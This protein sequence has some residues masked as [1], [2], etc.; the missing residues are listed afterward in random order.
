MQL[1]I[2]DDIEKIKENFKQIEQNLNLELIQERSNS[3]SIDEN[4]FYQIQLQKL[5]RQ[6]QKSAISCDDGQYYDTD[7]KICKSCASHCKSCV[8]PD[9]DEC[10]ICYSGYEF[11]TSDGSKQCVKQ[12]SGSSIWW[13]FFIIIIITVLG[14][15]GYYYGKKYFARKSENQKAI[16]NMSQGHWENELTN[17]NNTQAKSQIQNNN[18]EP[19][20]R[21]YN[22]PEINLSN[23]D[24]KISEISTFNNETE[25]MSN[26]SSIIR[27][28]STQELQY[29]TNE[30]F[31]QK[32]QKISN[33]HT[34]THSTVD[35]YLEISSGVEVAIKK[36]NY[37][38]DPSL[39]KLGLKEVDY[40][41][42]LNSYCSNVI[43]FLNCYIIRQQP[44]DDDEQDIEN[45]PNMEDSEEQ[46]ST[47]LLIIVMELAE[48]S[49][50]DILRKNKEINQKMTQ[51]QVYKFLADIS[52]V[53]SV[54]HNKL[55]MGHLNINPKN[56]LFKDGNWYIC[57][58]M[59]AQ[60]VSS[61]SDTNNKIVEKKSKNLLK[62]GYL[63]PEQRKNQNLL[64]ENKLGQNPIPFDPFLSDIFS[65]GLV[66]YEILTQK[67]VE[68]LNENQTI[69]EN[70]LI[71]NLMNVGNIDIGIVGSVTSML[72]WK[73][74]QRINFNQLSQRYQL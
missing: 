32:Y 63:S 36:Y 30:I 67:T 21:N 27:S 74:D 52:K 13:I 34:G 9:S 48:Y 51:E 29:I 39:L 11:E 68:G 1:E 20:F 10:T 35:K 41:K 70:A 12:S 14:I 18:Q 5:N 37:V 58:W 40:L 73:P 62:W 2:P 42:T 60:T 43:Q 19:T 7:D 61:L 53:F 46:D 22:A 56:I 57:D 44:K 47:H 59:Q 25:N 45:E 26:R 54:A 15:V 6:V 64:V 31:K 3:Q 8:G 33:I 55:R 50:L 65:F 28:Q 71:E 69:L 49:L 23:K 24:T 4:E 17:V 16:L 38:N 66:V 72:Q